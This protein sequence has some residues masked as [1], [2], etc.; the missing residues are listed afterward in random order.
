MA[1]A[2]LNELRRLDEQLTQFEPNHDTPATYDAKD[3]ARHFRPT[4]EFSM[5]RI[6]LP[7]AAAAAFALTACNN[8]DTPATGPAPTTDPAT[9]P[10]PMDSP[11][12]PPS[13]P[14]T[15]PPTDPTLPPNDPVDPTMPPPTDPTMQPPTDP[16]TTPPAPPT[17]QDSTTGT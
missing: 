13:D 15:P 11:T 16:T 2:S 10:P 8:H 1:A 4:Q 5:R 17:G 3:W 14:M 6:V 7:L 12:P 9:A